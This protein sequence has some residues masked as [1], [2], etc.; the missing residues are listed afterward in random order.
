MTPAR[1]AAAATDIEA[2]VSGRFKLRKRRGKVVRIRLK[3]MGRRNRPFFRIVAADAR[4]PRDG[5]TIEILGTYDPTGATDQDKY[6]VKAER[7]QYWLSV[8]AQPTET[9]R[10]ILKKLGI[11]RPA[12]EAKRQ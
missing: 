6:T 10:S 5:K 2:I 1:P 9:V 7:I 11:A 8:G 4:A 12:P 3:R